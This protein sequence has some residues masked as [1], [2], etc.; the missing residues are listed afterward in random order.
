MLPSV[1]K[2]TAVRSTLALERQVND[3]AGAFDDFKSSSD[4]QH[5]RYDEK[6]TRLL[7]IVGRLTPMEDQAS[8]GTPSRSVSIGPGPSPIDTRAYLSN[9]LPTPELVAIVSKV[10]NE[11]RG[12]VGRKKG[13][14]EDNSLKVRLLDPSHVIL[15]AH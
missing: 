13:G 3:L 5:R 8:S 11:A 1:S 6:L 12:R 14:A 4:E 9:P 2:S 10:V 15:S 7:D